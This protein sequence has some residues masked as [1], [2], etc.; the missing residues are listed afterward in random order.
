MARYA[1]GIDLG[2]QSARAVLADVADGTVLA[3]AQAAYRHGVMDRN[4]PTGEA[5]PPGW[6]LQHPA[7]YRESL[8]QAAREALRLS[9]VEPEAVAGVGL[10]VTAATAFPVDRE[11]VPLCFQERFRREK[12]AYAKL[13]KHHGAVSQAQALTQAAKRLREPW[14]ERLGGAV[15]CEWGL[16][17]LLELMQEAPEVYRETAQWCEAG[18]WLV[19]Q[20]TGR[21]SR[22][23]CAAGYKYAWDKRRG[24]PP[25][26]YFAAADPAF[27]GAGEKL[28][29]P[30]LPV[31]AR[32]GGLTAEM[33]VELGLR[34][35]TAVAAALVD[36]HAC[37]PAAGITGPGKLLMILGTSACHVLLGREART[38]PGISGAVE[39]AIFPGFW[40]YEAG[41]SCVGDGFAWFTETCLPESYANRARAEGLGAQEYLSRLAARREPGES[42]LL[43]LDWLNGNRCTLNDADLSGLILGLSLRSRPEDIYRALIESAAYGAR[44]IAEHFRSHGVPVEELYATGGVSRKNPLA[45]QIYADVLDLPVKAVETDQGA[46]LG[47]AI[48]AA[49]AGG[50]YDSVTQ[51]AEHMACR[52]CTLY[53]PNPAHAALYEGLYRDYAVLYEHFGRGGGLAIMK[54]LAA[55]RK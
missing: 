15:N 27:A 50:C 8:V 55:L 31:G 18:D 40:A 34:P 17:K 10:D 22:G 51:A 30:V 7:D 48:Y 53:L 39:D 6:A 3:S 16:P 9:G 41:Q 1:M 29:A 54:R 24:N 46:A 19:W 47:S 11:G 45:M 2:T 42:G 38:V 4:L 13:W 35:G 12:H 5:L 14:L 52:D 43:A 32:A 44:L 49:A 37:L 33:A 20:L 25:A 23:V 26:A 28:S 21:S 36:A